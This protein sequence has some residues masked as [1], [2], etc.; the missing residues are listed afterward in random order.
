MTKAKQYTKCPQPN[1]VN[2]QL[3]SHNKPKKHKHQKDINNLSE[4][5]EK[6]SASNKQSQ[7]NSNK[8]RQTEKQI[9]KKNAI[10]HSRLQNSND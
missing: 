2:R 1:Y 6:L 7:N 4:S 9:L 8:N 5:L 10:V 3:N